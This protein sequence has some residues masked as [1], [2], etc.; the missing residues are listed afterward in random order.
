MAVICQ[1]VNL[2]AA[3]AGSRLQIPLSGPALHVATTLASRPVRA[4]LSIVELIAMLRVGHL[5][6]GSALCGRCQWQIAATVDLVRADTGFDVH[7]R[8]VSG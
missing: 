1:G 3:R 7:R 2:Q 5:T 8:G 4:A 6:P